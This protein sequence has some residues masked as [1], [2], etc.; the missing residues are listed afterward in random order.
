MITLT[1]Q[2]PSIPDVETDTVKQ[3]PVVV[4]DCIKWCMQPA[5]SDGVD[6]PGAKASV[7]V[8]FPSTLTVPANGTAFTI[9][10]YN[11]TVDD[12][13]PFTS[14]SFEV[15][16]SG[17]NTWV[18]FAQMIQANLFLSRK[19]TP[20]GTILSGPVR[21]RVVVQWN[22]C[23]E[24]AGFSEDN[25]D[26]AG[27][28]ATGATVTY[29]NGVSPAYID[30]YQVVSRV[31][32][33]Q[34]TTNAWSPLFELEGYEVDR[35]CTGIGE[36]CVDYRHD[37]ESML[38]TDLP[39]LTSSSRITTLQGG[40]SLMRLFS[41]EYG[42]TY[43]ENCQARSGTFMK[44]GRVLAINA[45]FDVD[46]PY[47]MRRY[48]Y[49]HPLGYPP[50]QFVSDFLTTQPKNMDL[51]R[52]S[53][54][55]LWLLNNW[56]NE[57]GAGYDLVAQFNLYKEGFAGVYESFEYT[58]NDH[59][60]SGN[61]WHQPVNFNVSP[62]FVLANAPTLTE[63]ELIGYEISVFGKEGGDTIFNASEYLFYNV[64][65]CCE[66]VTDL[67]FL[68]PPGGIATQLI[69]INEITLQREGQEVAFNVNCGGSRSTRAKYGGRSL[70]SIRA[71]AQVNFSVFAPNSRE[72]I[73]WFKHLGQSPQ[74]WIRI[75]DDGGLPL[76]KKLI[77]PPGSG[78]IYQNG[79]GL[80]FRATGY[81]A[82]IPTQMGNEPL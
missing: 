55:W 1:T 17:V 33:Y 4:S 78:Q 7:T 13:H 2:P 6:T 32:V 27:L 59:L 62:A 9:W 40:R 43:R 56:Q 19:V 54:A 44:S 49:D 47:G 75:N 10:G 11:F 68:T 60:V 74:H 42:W 48:W 5:D 80:E 29:A 71:Y 76:A 70:Q 39:D 41:L 67:Y 77:L 61:K 79:T 28:E 81:L 14:E 69:T 65:H 38:Y 50:D 22:E 57:Y 51:C 3:P 64:G 36:V 52:G 37:I 15:E 58:V 12:S 31:G 23:R 26:F 25:M 73:R 21:Y 63:G 82:D 46:E 72:H 16:T 30:G 53:F 8:T 45:A 66:E 18:N 35:Q 24:Q 34:D 20:I